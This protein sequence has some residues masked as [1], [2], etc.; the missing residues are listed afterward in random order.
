LKLEN[1]QLDKIVKKIINDQSSVKKD[2]IEAD[3]NKIKEF[4]KQK[5]NINVNNILKTLDNTDY[6]SYAETIL[7]QDYGKEITLQKVLDYLKNTHIVGN[8]SSY[9][10][11][12]MDVA[13]MLVNIELKNNVVKHLITKNKLNDQECD[14]LH[15]LVRQQYDTELN[16]LRSRY[17][18]NILKNMSNKDKSLSDF[19]SRFFEKNDETINPQDK[20][21][22]S[23][24]FNTCL[25]FY[26]KFETPT[27]TSNSKIILTIKKADVFSLFTSF[28]LDQKLKDVLQKDFF[29]FLNQLQKI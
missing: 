5:C 25:C 14:L 21:E 11:N 23:N 10:D 19:F 18:T 29:K 28:S 3:K 4:F 26:F 20:N 8:E 6:R 27:A 2:K 13:K 16:S 12:L 17:Q 9:S 24:F 15:Q 1:E 7:K 22:I